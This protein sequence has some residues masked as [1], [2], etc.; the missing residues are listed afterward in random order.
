MR[1]S[2]ARLHFS[3]DLPPVPS[4][5]ATVQPGAPRV[6]IIV[7]TFDRSNVLQIALQSIRDQTIDE[8]EALVVGDAC[9]DD[10][11]AVVEEL[12][13]PRIRFHNLPA[14][15]GDQSGPNSVGARWARGR[16]LAWLN[17]DDLWFPDHLD[18]LLRDLERS[19]ADFAVAPYFRILE[20]IDDHEGPIGRVEAPEPRW[21]LR[22]HRGDV[23]LTSGWL[24]RAEL[25]A[26]VGD[27]KPASSVRYASSQDY[28]Y[29][30][31][32]SGARIVLGSRRSVVVVPSIVKPNSYGTR[33]DDEQLVAQRLVS[34]GDR[35]ALTRLVVPGSEMLR[36]PVLDLPVAD[37]PRGRLGRWIVR[38]RAR[39]FRLSSP[40]AVR[41]GIAPWEWAAWLVGLQL[42][43]LHALL[44]AGRG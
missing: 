41:A 6:S 25:A 11:A 36:S 18:T 5:A 37:R 35:A 12:G 16:F 10:T 4:T 39:L 23:F 8:W 20:L 26:R 42:G 1:R 7:P 14:N 40:L 31:W 38:H 17:H 2:I 29:R 13:D 3:R 9:T 15:T 19:N 27:W 32:S 34:A 33:R 28:F 44:R 24:M 21:P 30:C 22:I 43:G